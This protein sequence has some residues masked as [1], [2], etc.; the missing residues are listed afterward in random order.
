MRI[1][2]RLSNSSISNTLLVLEFFFLFYGY[3]FGKL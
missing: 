2:I 3:R 1:D